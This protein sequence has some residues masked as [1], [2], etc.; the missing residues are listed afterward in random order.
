MQ[1]AKSA[2][3]LASSLASRSLASAQPSGSQKLS[4]Q[5]L[6][7]RRSF[8]SN[9]FRSEAGLEFPRDSVKQASQ[10]AS[11]HDMAECVQ[12]LET[13]GCTYLYIRRCPALQKRIPLSE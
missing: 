6:L 10:K 1:R 7:P 5:K 2:L 9:A 8:L 13:I 3:K 11:I 12:R 4:L